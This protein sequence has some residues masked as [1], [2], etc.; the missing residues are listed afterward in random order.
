[1]A[2]RR[3]LSR[4]ILDSDKFLDMP[5]TTQALYIHLIMNAD[6]DGFLNNS[7][8]ITRMIGAGKKDF[9]LLI[10]AEFII[11]FNNGICAVKHWK[12]HNYIR[13]DR[14]KPTVYQDELSRLVIA[15][16]K[17]Y[18]ESKTYGKTKVYE[19]DT[20]KKLSYSNSD[21]II[22]KAEIKGDDKSLRDNNIE[23][24]IG[25][26]NQ[27]DIFL[28]SQTDADEESYKGD[29]NYE[30]SEQ[31]VDGIPSDDHMETQNRLD[32]ISVDKDSIEQDSKEFRKTEVNNSDSHY[33]SYKK[34]F[35]NVSYPTKEEVIDKTEDCNK[36]YTEYYNNDYLEK[37][38]R[39][40]NLL[41]ISNISCIKNTRQKLLKAR[42]K[43]HGTDNVINAIGN[44]EKSS[45]LKGQN[46]R[47]WVITFDWF[48]KP[49]NFIKVLEGNYDDNNGSSGENFI[50]GSS[51]SKKL[52]FNNFPQR[53][54][55]YDE[56]EKKLLGWN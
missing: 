21:E 41:G 10:S 4:T 43:E 48:V 35:K 38:M 33:K 20:N 49:N 32:E 36:D 47:G 9:E 54:Y 18:E 23:D 5:L 40:W 30:F 53:Q 16:N 31:K 11:D 26:D 3:M 6:D 22:P 19:A 28:E 24:I 2:E 29:G 50:R 46:D 14:Y 55:N 27:Q 56:L 34:T 39:K 17:V 45:F 51:S 42:I 25:K 15:S 7:Q 44:I 1:M 8:K 13:S 52:S 37:V 12:L